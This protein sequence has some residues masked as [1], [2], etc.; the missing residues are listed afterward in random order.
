MPADALILF[1]HGARDPAWRRPV[2]ALATRLRAALP[3]RWVEPAF[4]ELM[5]PALA[6][7]I[8]AA[9]RAGARQV[10]VAP[11]FWAAGG[12]LRKDVPALLEAARRTHPGVDFVLWPALGEIEAV[13]DAIAS[14][15]AERWARN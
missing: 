15:Y 3:G 4:L 11:V 13:L 1:A 6:D 8:D 14:V 9:V 10:L 2:D 12:H 5:T 7:A